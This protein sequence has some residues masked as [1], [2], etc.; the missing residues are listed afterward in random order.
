MLKMEENQEHLMAAIVIHQN[1]PRYVTYENWNHPSSHSYVLCVEV[2][3]DVMDIIQEIFNYM[4]SNNFIA[5]Y[6]GRSDI[7]ELR[8]KITKGMLH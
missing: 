4:L 7:K 8:E 5:M 3:I 1:H 2:G 6:V